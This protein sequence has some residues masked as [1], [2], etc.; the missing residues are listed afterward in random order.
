MSKNSSLWIDSVLREAKI[1]KSLIL[2]GNISDIVFNDY[3]NEYSSITNSLMDKLKTIGY[4]DVIYW[5]RIDGMQN[6][7]QS[8]IK[9]LSQES[10]KVAN[11]GRGEDIDLGSDISESSND[12]SK[13][14]CHPNDFL[15]ILL[16]NL[17]GKSRKRRAF[18]IDWG[19]Y[20]FGNPNSLLD[21][22]RSWLTY[23]SKAIMYNDNDREEI[24]DEK[25]SNVLILL[26]S[27][28]NTIP[29]VYY[30]KN[31]GVKQISVGL[32]TRK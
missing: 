15:P 17:K 22:E 27:N 26:T 25:P 31:P 32:P 19:Q 24:I 8:S 13:K 2:Y 20:L 16:S 6:I 7:S 21:E 14:F 4:D 23:L 12:T 18:I 11:N 1:R 29:P 30:Q 3:R 5:D 28:M 9:E 10:I